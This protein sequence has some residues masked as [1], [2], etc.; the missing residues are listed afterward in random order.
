MI[1]DIFIEIALLTIVLF[2]TV[3][4]VNAQFVFIPASPQLVVPYGVPY[5][6]NTLINRNIMY[7]SSQVFYPQF[8]QQDYWN[9]G[10]I[11]PQWSGGQQNSVAPMNNRRFARIINHNRIHRPLVRITHRPRV[12]IVPKANHVDKEVVSKAKS[13]EAPKRS[14]VAKARQILP[15]KQSVFHLPL[16][17]V[18]PHPHIPRFYHSRRKFIFRDIAKAKSFNSLIT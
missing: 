3:K 2:I 11:R 18:R 7:G 5:L 14:K 12:H 4:T 16:R 6:P 9:N 13:S 8:T 10:F 17:Q 15:R 1:L